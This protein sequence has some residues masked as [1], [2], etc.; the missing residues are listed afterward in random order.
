MSNRR[1]IVHHEGEVN[2]RRTGRISV[3]LADGVYA[4]LRGRGLLRE[5]NKR[6]RRTGAA[7]KPTESGEVTVPEEGPK[8][9]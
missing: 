8:S 3:I 4:Y 9:T 5:G 2:T 6:T 7:P 1:R